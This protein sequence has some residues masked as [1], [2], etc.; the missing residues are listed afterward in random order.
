MLVHLIDLCLS[1]SCY[2]LLQKQLLQSWKQK[3]ETLWTSSQCLQAPQKESQKVKFGFPSTPKSGLRNKLSV[4][5][6]GP[7]CQTFQHPPNF[8][9]QRNSVPNI[10]TSQQG[11]S[12]TQ[13][14]HSFQEGVKYFQDKFPSMSL[15]SSTQQSGS[16]SDLTWASRDQ[17][18]HGG[19]DW[20]ICQTSSQILLSCEDSQDTVEDDELSLGLENLCKAV[21]EQALD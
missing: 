15:G 7:E 17:L 16:F 2:S 11:S 12:L 18:A 9:L 14:R 3:I 8:F 6:S 1:Q 10:Y 13:K 5:W 21:T 4:P 19:L 20:S